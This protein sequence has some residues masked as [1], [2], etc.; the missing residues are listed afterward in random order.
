MDE[1]IVIVGA[2][3]AGLCTAIALSGQERRITV[4]ERDPP[5]P[6]GGVEP[7]FETWSRRGA[8]Q[9]R[10]SHAFLARLRSLI[11]RE[12]PALL[13]ALRGCGARE[14]SFAQGLPDT[15]R[16]QYRALSEDDELAILISRRT[17]L[18]VVIRRYVEALPGVDLRSSR[19]VTALASERD[20]ENRLVARGVVVEGETLEA[21]IVVDAAGRLS[22]FAEW[23]GEAG[24]PPVEES[25]SCAILYYTRFYRLLP[26]RSEPPRGSSPSTGDLGYL[27]FAVFPADNETFS[28]TLAVPEVEEGLRVAVMRPKTFDAICALLPGLAAWT[29]TE[30]S[31]PQ[32]RVMAMGAL[33]SRWREMVPGDAP[34]ALNLF[35]VGDSLVRTNPLFGRGCSFAAVEAFILRDVL[36]EGADPARRARLYSQRVRAELRPFYE[37][38]ASQDRSAARR[39]RQGLDPA[40]KAPWRSR[41]MRRFLQDG[42]AI[43]VR[44]D[45][46]LYR[47]ASRAFHMLAPP[48][49]WVSRP[50]TLLKAL[51]SLTRGRRAN[52]AFYPARAGPS[53]REMFSALGIPHLADLERLRAGA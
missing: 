13:D 22:P 45:I 12:H 4:V 10:H 9:L 23:L 39:A 42:L 11:A 51:V 29:D 41:L 19:R 2:G 1:R 44:R 48:R 34:V 52:A 38:M 50:R 20:A 32:S 16:G 31:T 25:E 17:T 14:L 15:L 53:R 18:E 28:I 35:S 27:K 46:E 26:G 7:A 49:G 6:E 33:E 8:T 37:E 5:P 36:A 40:Y 3:M 43:A 24:A 30:R 47:Q 21:D